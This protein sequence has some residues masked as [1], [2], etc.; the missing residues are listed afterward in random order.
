M[1]CAT[2]FAAPCPS[3][4]AANLPAA[5]F[6]SECATP[7]GG[8]PDRAIRPGPRVRRPGPATDSPCR[9]ERREPT[10]SPNAGS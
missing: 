4:G 9:A 5:K 1:E 2:P 3:C 7:M 8:A 6:C 10:R